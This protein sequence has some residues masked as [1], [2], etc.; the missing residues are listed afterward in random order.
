MRA[1]AVPTIIRD[2]AVGNRV[3]QALQG[4]IDRRRQRNCFLRG[5]ME[6]GVLSRETEG[7]LGRFGPEAFSPENVR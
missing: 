4:V 5:R 2:R 3:C 7:G 6:W 1:D